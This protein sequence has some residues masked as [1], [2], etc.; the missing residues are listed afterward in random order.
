MHPRRAPHIRGDVARRPRARLPQGLVDRLRGEYPWLSENDFVK[1]VERRLGAGGG[2]GGGARPP[3]DDDPAHAAVR[4]EGAGDG[5]VDVVDV[6]EDLALF[7]AEHNPDHDDDTFFSRGSSAAI[8]LVDTLA[9]W[10]MASAALR[11]PS[12]LCRSGVALTDG[13]SSLQTTTAFTALLAPRTSPRNT[14]G[15]R[16]TSSAYG[17]LATT[18]PSRIHKKS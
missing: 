7:R 18:I 2:G 15:G 13:R 1:V 17:Y 10:L 8:G 9:P 11:V 5:A 6:A 16:A 3:R 4:E 12:S 14:C